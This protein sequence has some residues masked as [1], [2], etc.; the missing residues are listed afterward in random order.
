MV[1][2]FPTADSG[3]RRGRVPAESVGLGFPA[4]PGSGGGRPWICSPACVAGSPGD[5]ED[6]AVVVDLSPVVMSLGWM[7]RLPSTRMF[8]FSAT[9]ATPA[10]ARASRTA[11]L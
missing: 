1:Q 4:E 8:S 6:H 5:A 9:K 11:T 10:L 2:L 3:R 7:S